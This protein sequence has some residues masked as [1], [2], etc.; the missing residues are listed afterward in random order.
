MNRRAFLVSVVTSFCSTRLVAAEF[1]SAD[2]HWQLTLRNWLSVLMPND[3][4]GAGGNSAVVWNYFKKLMLDPGFKKGLL[5][6]LAQLEKMPL[7]DN[8]LQLN[9]LLGSQNSI[10]G[11][12]NALMD[13]SI[14][15]YYGSDVGWKEIHISNAPQPLGYVIR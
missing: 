4:A 9:A 3:Q 11:F 14:E 2:D 8:Q 1:E 12:L 15:A 13:L 7:P 6:G 5:N 10:A